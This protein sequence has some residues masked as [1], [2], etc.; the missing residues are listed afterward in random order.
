MNVLGG[1]TLF[2][3]ISP[4][5]DFRSDIKIGDINIQNLKNVKKYI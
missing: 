2:C 5:K 3:Y 1:H 4:R